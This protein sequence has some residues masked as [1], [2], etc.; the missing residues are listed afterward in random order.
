MI[1]VNP[2]Q[3]APPIDHDQGNADRAPR[4]HAHQEQTGVL[5]ICEPWS[6]RPG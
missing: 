2:C 1:V 4:N 3:I 6:D 5:I